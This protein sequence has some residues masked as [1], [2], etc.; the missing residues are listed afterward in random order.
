MTPYTNESEVIQINGLS[1]ENR[2]D[3]VSFYGS[4][5]LTKDSIGLD[6]ARKIKGIIDAVLTTLE[7][8]DKNG[9]LP[10]EIETE[11]TIAVENPFVEPC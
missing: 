10:G 5:D 9:A 3:R 11:P 7:K 4:I 8:E 6:H 2:L 1:I